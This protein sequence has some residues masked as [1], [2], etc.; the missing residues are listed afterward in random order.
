MTTCG[1]S[2]LRMNTMSMISRR[3]LLTAIL[4]VAVIALLSFAVINAV[5]YP[6]SQKYELT[7]FRGSS[8]WGYDIGFDGR[9]VIHQPFVPALPGNMAFPDRASA[10]AAGRLVIDRLS[11]GASPSLGRDEIL[12]IIRK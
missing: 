11:S 6:H 8:G 3:S 7:V 1:N 10:S 2:S 5:S 12:R 9:T 4:A